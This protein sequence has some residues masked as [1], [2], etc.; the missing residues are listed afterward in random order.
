MYDLSAQR[1]MKEFLPY[2]PPDA[3]PANPTDDDSFPQKPWL[4]QTS[5]ESREEYKFRIS[6]SCYNCG[7]LI[8]DQTILN[9][10]EDTCSQQGKKRHCEGAYTPSSTPELPNDM[11]SIAETQAADITPTPR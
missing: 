7:K 6:H 9:T 4:I 1:G 2:M 3:Q 8:P 5:H 11:S 10:H